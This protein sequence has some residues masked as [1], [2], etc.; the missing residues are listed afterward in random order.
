MSQPVI[1][2]VPFQSQNPDQTLGSP[3][4][5]RQLG[6]A[7]MP[8]GA[9]VHHY[10]SRWNPAMTKVN[11]LFNQPEYY[12]PRSFAH[13]D[14]VFNGDNAPLPRGVSQ[15]QQYFMMPVNYVHGEYRFINP[16]AG[17]FPGPQL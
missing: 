12:S 6:G 9:Y 5:P 4:A 15:S 8:S 10:Q 13:A 16:Q 17:R 1:V 11:W 3:N 14:M 7:V 2:N